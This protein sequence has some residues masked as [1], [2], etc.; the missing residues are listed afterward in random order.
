MRLEDNDILKMFRAGSELAF[1][2]LYDLYADEL[3]RFCYSYTKTK[4]DAMDAAQEAF[5][6]L[7]EK[8]FSLR[9]D[10][11][12]KSLLFTIARN[13]ILDDFRK[14]VNEV[15]FERYVIY[16]ESF[17]TSEI[18]MNYDEYLVWARHAITRLPR[19]QQR[20]VWLSLF[21]GKNNS[22]IADIL[23]LKEKTVRNLLSMGSRSFYNILS[24]TL[25]QVIIF[26]CLTWDQLYLL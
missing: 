23:C 3:L 2:Q 7:W 17:R 12:F 26:I 5:M 1:N 20:V 4:V 25:F 22:Q 21:E 8:R 16:R 9:E 10:S 15:K 11:N 13:K 14:R 24:R 18:S 6:R 19:N